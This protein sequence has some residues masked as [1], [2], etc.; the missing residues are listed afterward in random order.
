MSDGSPTVSRQ[1]GWRLEALGYDAASFILR[2]L[3][4]DLASDLG[5]WT[6]E[7]LGPLTDKHK[8]VRRNLALAFPEK[9]PAEREAIAREYWN[10]IGRTFVEFPLMARLTPEGGRVEVAGLERLQAIAARGQPAI[11][12]SGHLSNWEVMM[13]VIVSSGLKSRVSYRPANNPLTD[14]RIIESRRRYGV[15]LFAA[16]GA[17]GTRELVAAL[18]HGEAV[19]ML[20]DQR[21]EGGVEAPFFGRMVKTAPGPA[22]FALKFRAPL[23]PMSVA[24]LHGARFRVTIHEPISLEPTGDQAADL[25][26]AVASINAFI[27]ARIRERP[28]EWL[29]AHR[30]WPLECYADVAGRRRRPDQAPEA[31]A[32]LS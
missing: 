30:R 10:K 20:N 2:L 27:E 12:V 5:G 1:L 15:K 19:A 24:R 14:R 18:R 32:S 17:D 6:I 22:R 26:A 25:A 11:L 9:S 3:P 13:A 28:A 21:D 29:W 8:V 4:L 31:A 23:V 7:R 16:K